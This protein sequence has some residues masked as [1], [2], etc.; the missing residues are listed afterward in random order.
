MKVWTCPFC[1][2]KFSSQYQENEHEYDVHDY[3]DPGEDTF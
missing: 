3:D 1:A 2:M